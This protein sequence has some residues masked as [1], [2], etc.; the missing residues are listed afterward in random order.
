MSLCVSSHFISSCLIPDQGTG[1]L[2]SSR[3]S[4]ASQANRYFRFSSA[5][6]KLA[7]HSWGLQAF[8]SWASVSD[9]LTPVDTQG[10]C[11]E[12]KDTHTHTH[13]H[14]HT[15]TLMQGLH[16]SSGDILLLHCTAVRGWK[17]EEEGEAAKWSAMGLNEYESIFLFVSWLLSTAS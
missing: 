7:S 16:G 2:A 11:G 14:K 12:G 1:L 10:D 5:G 6:Y 13:T 8:L 9:F 3:S 15:H 4:I 17:E